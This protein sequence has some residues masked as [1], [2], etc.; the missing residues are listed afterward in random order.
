MFNDKWQVVHSAMVC[1]WQDNGTE[2]AFTGEYC[3]LFEPGKYSCVLY[4][5]ASS[6]LT[7]ADP[8][9]SVLALSVCNRTCQLCAGTCCPYQ[10]APC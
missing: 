3:D 9:R 7:R 1:V 5:A 8:C 2:E 4:V 6:L 10:M